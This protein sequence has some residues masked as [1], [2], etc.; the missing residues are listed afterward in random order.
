MGKE[1]TSLLVQNE[2]T[3][4][5]AGNRIARFVRGKQVGSFVTRGISPTYADDSEPETSDSEQD[6]PE[7]GRGRG[8]QVLEEMVLFGNTLVALDKANQ[9][10]YVWDVAPYSNP[11]SKDPLLEQAVDREEDSDDDDDEEEDEVTPYA[12]LEFPN[13]FTP[14]KVVHPASYL[15]KVVVASK[16]G[17]LGVW[18][19]RTG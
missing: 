8:E 13:G 1:I 7:G 11:A 3:F 17:E 15:N 4:A 16:E 5:S 9:R 10:M 19:V 6:E 18:N 2:S 12:V 14:T